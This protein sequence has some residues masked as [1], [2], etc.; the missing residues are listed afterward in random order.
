MRGLLVALALCGAASSQTGEMVW[1]A[2]PDARLEING[3]P[4]YAENGHQWMRL[5]LR[6]KDTLPP[7]VW[8]GG[9]NPTGGR[10]RFRTDSPTVAV[11]LEYPSPPNMA[12]MHAFG[13][14]GVDL[15]LDGVYRGTAIAAKDAKAGQTVEKVYIDWRHQPRVM[16]EATLYLPLYKQ[17]KVLAVGVAKGAR[18][19]RARAFAVAKPVV[20]YGTSITQGGCASRSGMSYQAILGRMLNLDHVNLGFSGNGKG[21]P[22]V[23][24]MVASIDASCFVLD[25][26]Q[27]NRT[28]ES[29]KEVYALFLAVLREKHPQTPVLAITPIANG[30]ET[31][32]DS[33]TEGMRAH[34]R[35]VVSRQIAAGDRNLGWIEG[36]DLLGPGRLDG[37]VDGSHPNDLGF[38]WMAEGLAPRLAKI[39]AIRQELRITDPPDGAILNRHDGETTPAGLRV[40]V[41]GVCAGA[42]LVGGQPTAC[43]QGRFRTH[44]VLGRAEND[45]VAASGESRHQIRVLW[46]R[47]SVRRYRFSTDDNILFLK[48]IARNNYKSIFDNPYL[49][50]F[51]DMHRKYGVKVHFNLYYETAGFDLSQMPARYRSEWRAN[52]DWIR[53]TFHARA[54]EPDRP[55]L[56]APASQVMRDYD[57][58]TRQIRRFAG[59]E[60]L[61]PVTTIH[62]GEATREACA[63]LRAAGIRVLV[64]YFELS[65]GEPR[66]S[67]YLDRDRTAYLSGRDY[68][69][70]TALDLVFVRHDMVIN[71][72][73]LD[74]IVPRLEKLAADPH[75]SEVLEL[76]IHEQYFYPDYRS[77]LPDYRA[78]VERA[79]AWAASHGYKPVFYRDAFPGAAK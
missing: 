16:R 67:Y 4:W 13:Q 66:V 37:L 53:L 70:D 46:D 39:L 65:G 19:E 58:V 32:A 54:N 14:T 12:N 42:L 34:I 79:I 30:G 56:G 68:W 3:L 20:F 63:A 69:K 59:P 11:R 45:V 41:E 33:P 6:L 52:R 50:F 9:T 73:R 2:P 71:N 75:Q 48:D 78:R 40:A 43:T 28:V 74:D 77:Y 51:R 36:T 8:S 17:V 38:Q 31:N 1:I 72:V 64:G 10:I 27:N 15:Y 49:G 26:A 35:E 61:S 23:A 22:A 62:W 7:A 55:Y 44:I 21:E 47:D 29:L 60:L 57:L 24:R 18:M 25:Y 5:P 76:M